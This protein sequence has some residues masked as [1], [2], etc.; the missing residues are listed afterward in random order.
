MEKK[1]VGHIWR[2]ISFLSFIIAKL[3][4]NQHRELC[5]LSSV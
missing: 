3:K 4:V 2:L 1:K 5:Q